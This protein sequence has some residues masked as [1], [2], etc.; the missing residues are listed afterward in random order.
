[1]VAELFQSCDQAPSGG[2]RLQPVKKVGPG[3]TI[4]LLALDH[5]IGHDEQRMGDGPNRTRLPA[6]RG[7]LPVLRTEVGPFGPRGAGAACTS[8]VRT[9][10]WPWRVLPEGRFPAL[11]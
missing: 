9:K 8:T 5:G 6:P 11:S 2:C 10:R 7:Q 1:M 3:F 4:R